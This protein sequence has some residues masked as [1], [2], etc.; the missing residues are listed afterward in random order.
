MRSDC[1]PAQPRPRRASARLLAIALTAAA[2]SIPVVAVAQEHAPAAQAEA[3]AP[4]QPGEAAEHAPEGIMTTVARLF[5]FA[6]LAGALVYFLKTPVATYLASRSTQ[7]RQ[8]LITA[9]EMREA[10][11]AELVR[12]EAKL[13]TLPGELD[14]LK[15]RGAEDVKAEQVRIAAAASAERERLVAQT[16]REIE[17]RLRV[18]RRELTEHAA[19]LA[20]TFAQ[21]RLR[22]TI[23]PE[24]QIRMIDRYTSQ[25]KEAR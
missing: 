2:L 25:L 10:A 15:A 5:N 9:A 1:Q 22:K 23:T 8:D 17:M 11:T 18:A 3:H 20:I 13:K 14:A 21:E 24:D 6:L 4:A 7:I 19:A 12:I 16:R